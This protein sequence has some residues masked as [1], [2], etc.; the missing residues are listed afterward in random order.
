MND[1]SRG[2][3]SAPPMSDKGVS[4]TATDRIVV[5]TTPTLLVSGDSSGTTTT[6]TLFSSL[7]REVTD[8]SLSTGEGYSRSDPPGKRLHKKKKKKKRDGKESPKREPSSFD[9]VSTRLHDAR[10]G[11][12]A[13]SSSPSS[14]RSAVTWATT[15]M[16][17]KS[18]LPHDEE[19]D[20]DTKC[21]A[22]NGTE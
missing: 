9:P 13:A 2:E 11:A 17:S 14:V 6:T 4:T 20:W 21:L 22:E 10:V 12:A 1:D 8:S 5:A 18:L 3:R 7:P 15:D 19:E 16:T